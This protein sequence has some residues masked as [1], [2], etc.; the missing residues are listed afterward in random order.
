MRWLGVLRLPTLGLAE[1]A[2]A[3]LRQHTERWPLQPDI[4]VRG[5]SPACITIR[6]RG[7]YTT[8]DDFRAVHAATS[9]MALEF[10]G[11]VQWMEQTRS[12]LADPLVI[13]GMSTIP[14]EFV[15]M[16][17]LIAELG[18]CIDPRTLCYDG[19]QPKTGPSSGNR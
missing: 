11:N 13:M 6:T 5:D 9:I 17:R 2:A 18:E 7:A 19:T 10:A 4:R 16:Q 3:Y 12:K 15:Q 8:H 1:R 14:P